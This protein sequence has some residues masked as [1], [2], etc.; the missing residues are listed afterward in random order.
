MMDSCTANMKFTAPNSQ[1]NAS[2]PKIIM[3]VP[4]QSHAAVFTK[5]G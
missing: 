2:L 3:I 5:L 4:L 1:K